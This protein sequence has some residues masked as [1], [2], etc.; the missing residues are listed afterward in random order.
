MS[1]IPVKCDSKQPQQCL[2]PIT[3][4]YGR[5][6][7]Y[8]FPLRHSNCCAIVDKFDRPSSF[9]IVRKINIWLRAEKLTKQ[10][11]AAIAIIDDSRAVGNALTLTS[12]NQM[13]PKGK[14]HGCQ[15]VVQGR[16]VSSKKKCRKTEQKI[17]NNFVKRFAEM[18]SSGCEFSDRPTFLVEY[19]KEQQINDASAAK[20]QWK[21]CSQFWRFQLERIEWQHFHGCKH[22][23][24]EHIGRWDIP[25]PRRLILR[26][27]EWL[28]LPAF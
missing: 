26:E 6:R 27:R 10:C 1:G 28:L 8:F 7:L 12:T 2:S 4:G 13:R 3:T 24:R 11:L 5:Q 9:S 19:Y 21:K 18:C 15:N 16:C 23:L 25:T 20:W 22:D 14:R 17:R